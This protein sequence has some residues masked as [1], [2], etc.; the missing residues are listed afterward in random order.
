VGIILRLKTA[1]RSCEKHLYQPGDQHPKENYILFLCSQLANSSAI[2]R[3]VVN[4]EVRR[5]LDGTE[6]SDEELVSIRKEEG[7]QR[8]V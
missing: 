5:G 3:A 7:A 1:L 4:A 8:V 2:L 6:A